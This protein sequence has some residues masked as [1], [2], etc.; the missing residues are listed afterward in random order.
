[1][2][3]NLTTTFLGQIAVMKVEIRA[4]EK[5]VVTSRPNLQCRYDLIVDEAGILSR[6]QVKYAGGQPWAGRSG[7]VSV[8]L[9]KW[10]NGG[11]KILPCYKA[12]EI[13][14]LFV[15]VEKIDQILR[16]GPEMFHGRRELQIRIAPAKNNQR[17]GCIMASEYVW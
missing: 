4:A 17:K 8:G 1:V 11:R 7:V 12:T 3:H 2:D 5:G 10:R 15:Y 6:A 14:L 16:F 9:R 13:D